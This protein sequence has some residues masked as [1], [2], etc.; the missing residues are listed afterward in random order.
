[1]RKKGFDDIILGLSN[2]GSIKNQSCSKCKF[3]FEYCVMH[4]GSMNSFRPTHIRYL[5]WLTPKRRERF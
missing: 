3:I 1:M 4:A 2:L 5:G